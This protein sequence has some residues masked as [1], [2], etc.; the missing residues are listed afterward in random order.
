MLSQQI[1]YYTKMNSFQYK[2]LTKG[3]FS[4]SATLAALLH[5]KTRPNGQQPDTQCRP[6]R[7]NDPL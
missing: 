7:S 2:K 6:R 3:T 4:V 5:T 1:H